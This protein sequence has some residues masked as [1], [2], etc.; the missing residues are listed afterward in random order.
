MSNIKRVVKLAALVL[1]V[2][3]VLMAFAPVLSKQLGGS[4]NASAVTV[5]RIE[6]IIMESLPASVGVHV[7]GYLPDPCTVIDMIVQQRVDNR[8]EV[9]IVATGDPDALCIQV[10]E[11]FDIMVSL[12]VL[13][14][15]AGV[16]TVDVH[17]VTGEFTFAIDNVLDS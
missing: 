10:I 15:P 11:P 14:L 2:S 12:D 16:Y 3:V 8:F 17:G 7:Y 1:L 6:I 5:E 4:P 9:E 13:G